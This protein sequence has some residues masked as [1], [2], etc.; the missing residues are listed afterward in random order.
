[1]G[2]ADAGGCAAKRLDL[3]GV[4]MSFILEQVKPVFLMAVHVHLDL[5]GAGIDLF[6]LVQPRKDSLVFEPLGPDGPH[7]HEAHRLAGAAQRLAQAQVAL[8]GRLHAR[9]IRGHLVQL[10]PKGGVAAMI[11]PIG[12]D[13]A[14]LGDGGIAFLGA[15]ILL[16][17]LEVVQVHGQTPGCREARQLLLAPLPEAFEH[18]DGCRLGELHMQRRRRLQRRFAGLHRVDDVLFDALHVLLAERSFQRIDRRRAHL[19][20]LALAYQLHAL[21][22]GVSPLVELPR[23]ILHRKD[24]RIAQ[25]R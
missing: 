2:P 10:R 1:M 21:R 14:D 4:V 13:H 25:V 24:G 19:R 23:Q 7:V 6:G 3:G 12:V 17:K 11:G 16:A 8:E 22:R 15:E 18:L 9:V 20:T 5:D